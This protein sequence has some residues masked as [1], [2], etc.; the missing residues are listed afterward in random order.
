MKFSEKIRFVRIK[1][2][3]SQERLAQELHVSFATINR[4]E[5][6]KTVPREMA[7][8]LF[9]KF[10]EDNNIDFNDLEEGKRYG[11]DK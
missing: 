2:G 11:T 7:I 5:N 1:L 10:C 4:W 3:Y 8:I 9:S 6:N